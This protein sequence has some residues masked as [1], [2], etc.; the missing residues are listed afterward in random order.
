VTVMMVVRQIK[1]LLKTGEVDQTIIAKVIGSKVSHSDFIKM[2]K[3]ELMNVCKLSRK[4]TEQLYEVIHPA[5]PKSD[6]RTLG[7]IWNCKDTGLII[8]HMGFLHDHDFTHLGLDFAIKADD[9][10]FPMHA[11]VYIGKIGIQFYA[12]VEDILHFDKPTILKSEPA[13][14]DYRKKKF[15]TYLK[16]SKMEYMPRVVPLGR[17]LKKD[18]TGVKVVRNYTTVFEE[19]NLEEEEKEAEQEK[20]EAVNE[21]KKIKGVGP[22]RGAA[23]YDYGFHSVEELKSA[24]EKDLTNCGVSNIEKFRKALKEHLKLKVLKEKKVEKEEKAIEIEGNPYYDF[25]QKLSRK[26]NMPLSELRINDLLTKIEHLLWHP[27]SQKLKDDVMVPLKREWERQ[28]VENKLRELFADIKKEGYEPSPMIFYKTANIIYE[29]NITPSEENLEIM[30][31]ILTSIY[32]NYLSNL[33]DPAEAVGIVAAQSIG[34]PGTQ[35][36]MRTFHYAGVAE[37]NVTLGLPRLIEIVDARKVPKTPVT[38]IHLLPRIKNDR[39]QA[40][41]IAAKI[42]RTTLEEIADIIALDT[43]DI[44]IVIDKEELA[45]Y[46][47]KKKDIRSLLNKKLKKT[48]KL[49]EEEDHFEISLKEES[50]QKLEQKVNE[51]SQLV[52]SGIPELNRAIIRKQNDEFVIY[53]EGSNLEE[54]FAVD[55][56]DGTKTISNNIIEVLNVLGVEAARNIIIKE[57][58]NVLKEQ[59]LI[60]DVRHI[61]LVSDL[62]TASGKVQ[63]IGRHGISGKKTSVLA[64]AAFEITTNVILQAAI[65]G[66]VDHL[67]GVAENII[68]GLPVKLG[69]GAIDVVYIPPPA[70]PKKKKAAKST[71]KTVGTESAED[72]VKPPGL[73]P[74]GTEGAEEEVTAPAVTKEAVGTEGA[75]EEV[76]APA[77]TKE[78]VGTEGAEDKVKPPGLTPVGTEGAEESLVSDEEPPERSEEPEGKSEKPAEKED[79]KAAKEKKKAEKKK[80]KK[81]S[82]KSKKAKRDDEKKKKKEKKK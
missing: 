52:V 41:R 7:I 57:A 16:I 50:Y 72:K 21:F 61:M 33:I 4:E 31:K 28:Q 45:L 71:K 42:K 37:M 26:E 30:K 15:K 68:V 5:V 70:S 48:E 58:T 54:V 56:V 36:T 75:E 44:K 19:I 38:E 11:F 29:K 10:A 69:T 76:T 27:H 40:E 35:M 14:E 43:M 24:S 80:G 18:E 55:G 67:G 66:E 62:M 32:E 79:R 82:K 51:L 22:A 25:I 78:A 64:R 77:V 39:E 60:V 59:G 81:A 23:F 12:V 53:T 49:R 2:T 65:T 13:P 1:K 20:K 17:F 6:E 8:D 3:R 63:A 9:F 34:E 46:D 47:L 74:V 73:T